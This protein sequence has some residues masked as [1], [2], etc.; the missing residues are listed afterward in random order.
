MQARCTSEGTII[1][2]YP[3]PSNE[4]GLVY[5]VLPPGNMLIKTGT[6]NK[7]GIDSTCSA[8]SGASMKTISAPDST[9]DCAREIAISNPSIAIASVLPMIK[10]SSARRTFTA[11]SILRHIES[12][13]I[14]DLPSRC[15]QRF[16]KLWS[17]IC[18]PLIPAASNI[19]TI[20]RT[21]WVS[22]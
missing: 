19:W 8:V 12:F 3:N 14:S 9:I 6:S 2:R 20:R 22:P 21:C 4:S 17:S 18:T 7:Q 10:K 13:E 15:P 16:G 5:G 11:D 1:Y